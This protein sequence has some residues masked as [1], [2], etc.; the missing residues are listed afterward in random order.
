[1]SFFLAFTVGWR[2]GEVGEGY[3]HESCNGS[4]RLWH[5]SLWNVMLAI[6][7]DQIQ[8]KKWVQTKITGHDC[9][10]APDAS[11]VVKIDF[12]FQCTLIDIGFT[13]GMHWHIALFSNTYQDQNSSPGG[14]FA[15]A[16]GGTFQFNHSEW[17]G[18]SLDKYLPIIFIHSQG[19]KGQPRWKI[20]NTSRA[21]CPHQYQQMFAPGASCCPSRQLG[22]P[23][24]ELCPFYLR[25][26]CPKNH[27]VIQ[28]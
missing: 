13:W 27:I 22:Y 6:C 17:I 18:K 3:I 14:G 12:I 7:F 11:I 15:V 25:S 23:D 5:Q 19:M 10:V 24:R 16:C 4:C 20:W 8:C 21:R 9:A 26:L 28:I 2:V 1:M